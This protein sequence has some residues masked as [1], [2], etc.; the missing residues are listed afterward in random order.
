MKFRNC[1]DEK[2]RQSFHFTMQ[3]LRALIAYFAVAV[4]F[5]EKFRASELVLL[6]DE[7]IGEVVL[8]AR[9]SFN[10]STIPASL[11]YRTMGL[12]TG[13]LNQHIPVYW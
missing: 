3:I 5:A 10:A 11:D 1:V 13:D 6:G 7:T 12:L 8:S 9:P 2:I 4:A